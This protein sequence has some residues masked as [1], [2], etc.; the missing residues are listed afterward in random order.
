MTKAKSPVA[1][2]VE[3]DDEFETVQ[4]EDLANGHLAVLRSNDPC[5]PVYMCEIKSAPTGDALTATVHWYAQN[6]KSKA[7]KPMTTT[8]DD[9]KARVPCTQVLE[10][11]ESALHWG[12]PETVLDAKHRLQPAVVAALKHNPTCLFG[13]PKG[14]TAKPRPIPPPKPT[15]PTV[16]DNTWESS[17]STDPPRGRPQRDRKQ[18]AVFTYETM[19]ETGR[20]RMNQKKRKAEQPSSRRRGPL[21]SSAWAWRRCKK[22]E[23]EKKTCVVVCVVH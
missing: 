21:R 1:P 18:R 9:T 12:S 15:A 13:K 3:L 20:P 4:A 23:R 10:L 17:S 11:K 22:G 2:Q 6:P 14:S 16:N 7:W 8:D 5:E 19:G